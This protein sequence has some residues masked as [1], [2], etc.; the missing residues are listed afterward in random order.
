[1]R[2]YTKK[3]GNRTKRK[4]G[5]DHM[6]MKNLNHKMTLRLTDELKN[7][8]ETMAERYMISPSDFIRQCVSQQMYA[9]QKAEA[10]FEQMPDTLK[11]TLT[12]ALKG[13][14]R[15]ALENG[16]DRKADNIDNV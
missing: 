7:F 9:N 13:T 11:A 8:V 15:K 14:E 12:E 4:E 10:I 1:M 16:T 5:A 3:F 6:Y 2:T